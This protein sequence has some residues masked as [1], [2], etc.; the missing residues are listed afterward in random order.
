MTRERAAV[1]PAGWRLVVEESLP[2]TSDTLIRLAEDGAEA[3]L[4]LLA[5]RQTAG[6]ARGGRGWQA[7]EGNLYLSVLLRPPGPAREAAQWSLLAGVALAE[8][9]AAAD[10]DPAALRLK[11]P[12]DLLRHGAKVAGILADAAL[13]RGPGVA[14]EA[15]LGWLVL[16]FGVNLATAPAIA[17]RPTATL[18]RR[19]A[20]EAFAARLLD[21]LGA[22]GAVQAAEGFAP[23]RAAWQALG[24][25]PGSPITVR[26]GTIGHG[27]A[28]MRMG[29]YAGLAEDGTLL[30]ETTD[31]TGGRALTRVAAGEVADAREAR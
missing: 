5:L 6:R 13:A 12:N 31:P 30:I 21:R 24:P 25:A 2:S 28:R 9:A 3:G 4:A 10:P 22:W 8:A 19:E 17:D 27:G 16:G 14:A 15:P 11:W 7:G 20:P 29:R 18:A 1:A 23:V 26:D